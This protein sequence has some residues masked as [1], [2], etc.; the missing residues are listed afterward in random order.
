MTV[1]L[2]T[3]LADLDNSD[4]LDN[5]EP[6]VDISYVSDMLVN[7]IAGDTQQIGNPTLII[8]YV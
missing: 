8:A 1:I 3:V 2:F 4:D 6:F 7:M 5:D